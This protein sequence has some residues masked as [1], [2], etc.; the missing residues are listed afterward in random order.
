[1]EI[2][3][4]DEEARTLHGFLADK[5]PEVRREIAGTDARALDAEITSCVSAILTRQLKIDSR[6]QRRLADISVA[7]TDKEVEAE[8]PVAEY[9]HRL[10]QLVNTVLTETL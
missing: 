7:L 10:N 4:T 8:P 1:M 2:R 6:V 5:L 3:L 9:C